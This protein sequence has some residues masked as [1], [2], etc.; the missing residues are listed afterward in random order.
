MIR[1]WTLV[2]LLLPANF[3]MSFRYVCNGYLANGAERE[4]ECGICDNEHAARWPSPII[5][6]VVDPAPRPANISAADWQAIIEASFS[7]WN[8][9]SG[10]NLKF[11]QI[12]ADS[13]RELGSNDQLH[14]IFWITDRDEWR[15]LVGSGE[16]GTL[17]ATLP[18]YTCD[19]EGNSKRVIH[20]ADLVLNGL[21]HINWARDCH[22]DDCISVQSTLVHE[23]GHF[24][25]LDHPC[26]MCDSSI[27]SARAGYD[28][29]TPMFDDM[30]GVRALYPDLADAG[31]FG[32]PCSADNNCRDHY[33]C[34]NDGTDSYCAN[35]CFNDEDCDQGS[36]CQRQNDG[37]VKACVFASVESKGARELGDN[38]MRGPCVE[39]LLCAGAWEPNFFCFQPCHTKDVCQ[40]GEECVNLVD[41]TALCVGIKDKGDACDHRNLCNDQLYCVFESTNEGH[42]RAPC[43]STTDAGTGCLEGEHCEL[44]DGAVELCVPQELSLDDSTDGF[45]QTAAAPPAQVESDSCANLG[46]NANFTPLFWPMLALL[47]L[48]RHSRARK[49]AE[50]LSNYVK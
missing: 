45:G 32:Y 7:A 5:P 44:V 14:E 9:V 23:L 33:Q 39:P 38:C 46:S 10:S 18:R 13:T 40:P 15:K 19:S 50:L 31:G 47:V 37:N 6:V 16:F 12:N 2:L 1:I 11:M 22:S 48:W 8:N 42:C 4:D 3:G 21:G 26:L 41:G 35:V 30:Q 25:G 17:G 27:M 20:D 34:I 49:K 43:S 36:I 29:I 28:I 24:F